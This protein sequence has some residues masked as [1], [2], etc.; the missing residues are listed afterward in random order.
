MLLKVVLQKA[1]ELAFP[2]SI[3]IKSVARLDAVL[4]SVDLVKTQLVEAEPSVV[5]V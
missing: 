1:P 5:T 4:A 2:W 3:D